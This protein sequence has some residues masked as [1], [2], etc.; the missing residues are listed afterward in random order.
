MDSEAAAA[1]YI[2]RMPSRVVLTGASLTSGDVVAVAR[3]GARVELDTGAVT[4]FVNE[5]IE[6]LQREIVEEH[7]YE[8]VDH[9]LVLYVRKSS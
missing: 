9:E 4:E 2:P 7:G 6:A 5:R 8:L 1:I 3:G